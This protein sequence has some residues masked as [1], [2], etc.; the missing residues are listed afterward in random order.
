MQKELNRFMANVPIQIVRRLYEYPNA[1]PEFDAET[2]DNEITVV[3]LR[4]TC[5]GDIW[6][7]HGIGT[8][9][10][11]AKRAAAKLA[12]SKLNH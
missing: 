11:N 2:V 3:P 12:L 4:F 7:V 8:N 1:N 9:K 5:K 10:D 6:V